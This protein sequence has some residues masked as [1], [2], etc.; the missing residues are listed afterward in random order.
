MANLQA[1]LQTISKQNIE[2]NE[3][4]NLINDLV[5]ENTTDGSFITFFWGIIN[6][7]TMELTYVNMGHNPPLLVRNKT[8]IKLKIGGMILGVMPT[9][10]PYKSDSVQLESNDLLVLFTDG[11]TEAMNREGEEY[12]DEKFE[13][14]VSGLGHCSS[15]EALNKILDDVKT[16]IE[17]APQSDDIT[18]LILKVK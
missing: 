4:S 12:S 1:F 11:I 5:S 15:K 13:D 8:I 14:F 16:F 3:A 2:L 6:D 10:D 17:G 18:A 7:K 9:V